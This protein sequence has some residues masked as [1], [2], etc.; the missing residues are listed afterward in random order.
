M[1]NSGTVA[2]NSEM[3]IGSLE[4]L[5]RLADSVVGSD[6]RKGKIHEVGGQLRRLEPIIAD[7]HPAPQ[8]R[9]V[10]HKLEEEHGHGRG[11]RG[12]PC[13]CKQYLLPQAPLSDNLQDLVVI[14]RHF[15]RGLKEEEEDLFRVKFSKL[16]GNDGTRLTSNTMNS[17]FSSKWEKRTNLTIE[18][19]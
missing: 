11:S 18:A 7:G 14:F 16:R 1:K 19:N 17:W 2:K 8:V 9:G 12:K 6:I 13:Q 10:G 5:T 4:H 3:I 15:L